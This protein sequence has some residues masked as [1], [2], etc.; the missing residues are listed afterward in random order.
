[1]QAF[2][3]HKAYSVLRTVGSLWFAAVLLMLLL[4]AMA[5]ATVF[6]S[7][8]GT[9]QALHVFYRTW[10]FE[11]LLALLGVNVLSAVVARYPFQ[12]RQIGFV[13]THLSLLAVLVG[14]LVT[15]YFALDGQLG[16][17]EGQSGDRFTVGGNTITLVNRAAATQRSL[18]LSGSVVGGF[19]AGDLAGA[20]TLTLD[21]VTVTFDRYLPDT[22]TG[23]IVTEHA[24]SGRPAVEIVLT[25]NGTDQR[26]WIFADGVVSIGSTEAAYRNVRDAEMFASILAMEKTETQAS[27]GTVHIELDGVTHEVAVEDCMGTPYRIDD[28]GLSLRVLRYLPHATVGSDNKITNASPDPVNPALEIEL[29]S[30]EVSERRIAFA[31]FPGFESMHGKSA[32]DGVKLRFVRPD[33]PAPRAPIEVF[34]GPGGDMFVRFA[35]ERMAPEVKPLAVGSSMATPWPGKTITLVRKFDRARRTQS[36]VPVHPVRQERIAAVHATVQTADDT[37]DFWLQR[38]RPRTLTIGEDL[39]ELSY[40]DKIVPLGFAVTL[41]RFHIGYYPGTRRPRSFESHVTIVD[42][43]T[44][45][46]QSQVISMNHPTQFGGYNFYQSSYRLDGKA[47]VSFLSVASDP[48]LPIVFAGYIGTMAGMVMVLVTRMRD[49]R[50]GAVNG[51]GTERRHGNGSIGGRTIP[52]LVPGEKCQTSA[53]PID[54]KKEQAARMAGPFRLTSR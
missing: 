42:P 43:A 50:R 51:A 2:G 35:R 44:G 1:M 25:E 22:E 37:F 28:T 53:M 19:D 26:Q 23:E 13:I 38:R 31:R 3:E 16:L 9:E 8:H 5:C 24:T 39:Y 20:P 36:I 17:A 6:E 11:W 32:L 10:W 41:N 18:D 21:D 30:V 12:R 14:A 7:T 34:A 15:K 52:L 47:P 45:R 40:G 29:S 46:S 54:V 33:T 4:I 27:V 49:R 48:G